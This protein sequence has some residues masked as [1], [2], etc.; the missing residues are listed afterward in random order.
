MRLSSK[1][2]VIAFICVGSYYLI[3]GLDSNVKSDKARV[4]TPHPKSVLNVKIDSNP[5]PHDKLPEKPVIKE[6]PPKKAPKQ[7]KQ[8]QKQKQQQQQPSSPQQ[9]ERKVYDYEKLNEA[10]KSFMNN[11]NIIESHPIYEEHVDLTLI[12]PENTY[13]VLSRQSVVDA[14]GSSLDALNDFTPPKLPPSSYAT[15]KPV[16]PGGNDRKHVIFCASS[17]STGTEYL[18]GK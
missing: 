1:L 8:K 16:F 4:H 15:E 2:L 5:V 9:Q 10:Y 18:S 3:S 7:Q 14:D 6:A 11:K 13:P 17:G 12:K